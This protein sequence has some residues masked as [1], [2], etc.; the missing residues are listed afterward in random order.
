M[1]CVFSVSTGKTRCDF[2][3]DTTERNALLC[4]A[5][6]PS[7]RRCSSPSNAGYPAS[8]TL[9]PRRIGPASPD[10]ARH[11]RPSCRRHPPRNRP[12][13]AGVSRPTV[14]RRE[15]WRLGRTRNSS[16]GDSLSSDPRSGNAVCTP[17]LHPRL[18]YTKVNCASCHGVLGT[19][20]SRDAPRD[21]L[22]SRAAR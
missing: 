14:L 10:A 13:Q 4:R 11:P 20:R 6:G 8:S 5:H 12:I 18:L 22:S 2:L 15:V 3:F 9:A 16:S 1:W 19:K 7:S 17:F 21:G